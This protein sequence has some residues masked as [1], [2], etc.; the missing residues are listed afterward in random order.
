MQVET[1]GGQVKYTMKVNGNEGSGTTTKA[2][3]DG[4]WHRIAITR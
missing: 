3:N 2:I 4:T 1:V